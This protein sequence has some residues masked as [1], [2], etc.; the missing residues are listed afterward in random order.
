MVKYQKFILF[1]LI[2]FTGL[3]FLNVGCSSK[4]INNKK[5]M[6]LYQDG[7]QLSSKGNFDKAIE[8][9]NKSIEIC[10][11]NN[12]ISGKAHNYNEIGNIYTYKKQFDTAREYFQKALAIYKGNNM[13]A[14]VSKSFDNIAK[15]YIRQGNY[16]Q[17][18]KEYEKL[19]AWDMESK[20]IL[21]AGITKFNMALLCEK[22]I[23]DYQKA[24]KFYQEALDIFLNLK[25]DKE[26]EE[27][28]KGIKRT[29]F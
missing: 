12:F 4:K 26:A 19:A 20:N 14:E 25:R 29:T 18:L 8:K 11:K 23:K 24:K 22:Y 9:F 3:L 28:R 17:S 27:A 21:G 16:R 15:T 1:T 7:M 10:E 5:A 2:F 6:F 13:A